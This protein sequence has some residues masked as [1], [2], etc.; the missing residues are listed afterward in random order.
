MALQ[1]FDGWINSTMLSSDYFNK[2][3]IDIFSWI[4][5]LNILFITIH[6]QL[7]HFL[8]GDELQSTGIPLIILSLNH[9]FKD[10]DLLSTNAPIYGILPH[11]HAD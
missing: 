6:D 7:S 3:H 5:L 9:F 1:L 8:S 11:F 2:R 10:M 4:I